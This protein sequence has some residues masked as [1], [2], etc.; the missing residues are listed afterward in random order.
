VTFREA[1]SVIANPE[2]GILTV[3]A[4]LRQH[5]KLQEFLDQ[6]LVNAAPGLDRGHDRRRAAQQ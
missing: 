6:V 3:R 2:A 5:D 4:T 1:S